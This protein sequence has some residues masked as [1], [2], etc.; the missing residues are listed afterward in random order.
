MTPG[1]ENELCRLAEMLQA[2]DQTLESTTPLR[3]ALRKAGLALNLGFIRG[4][5]P[6]IERHYRQLDKPLT[7]VE[8]SSLR[9][10]DIDP[11]IS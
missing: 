5:R 7:K 3:E 11:E 9:N 8:R 2:I 1:D 4:L 6:E 10:M